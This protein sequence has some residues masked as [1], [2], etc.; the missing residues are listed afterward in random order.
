VVRTKKTLVLFLVLSLLAS[1]GWLLFRTDSRYSEAQRQVDARQFGPALET[2]SRLLGDSGGRPEHL[3]L[4]ARTA[5]RAAQYGP[6]DRFIRRYAETNADPQTAAIERLLVG[7]QRGELDRFGGGLKFCEDNPN[8]PEVPYV[9]EAMTEGYWKV[10]HL[11]GALQTS[12][13]W[14]NTNPGAADRAAAL[15]WRAR[16]YRNISSPVSALADARAALEAVPDAP[17]AHALI[18]E[19][20]TNSD[21]A[22]ALSHFRQVLADDP[23]RLDARMGEVRC[24]RNRNEI[25][26]A[27]AALTAILADHPDH[28]PAFLERAKIAIDTDQPATAVAELQRYLAR[29]PRSREALNTL[30]QAYIVSGRT[31]DAEATRK[32]VREIENELY[33]TI[34]SQ[35]AAGYIP[36]PPEG[37]EVANPGPP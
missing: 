3:L 31:A 12:T 33:E 26:A 36:K 34:K 22:A 28:M 2:L 14:L 18:G 24:L 10:G 19:L 32:T 35:V 16:C 20:L 25:V 6:A 11:V 21:P 27:T 9:L 13:L 1:A 4:A 23:K 15:V 7:I 37:S 5:R 17:D 30:I 8:H 29:E